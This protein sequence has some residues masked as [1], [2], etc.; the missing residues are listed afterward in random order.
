MFRS[1]LFVSST[2][3]AVVAVAGAVS[4]AGK[5]ASGKYTVFVGTYTSKGSKGIYSFP[6]DVKTAHAG[7]PILAAASEA[8]SFV[9]ASPNHRFL[10]ACNEIDKFQGKSAGSVTGFA[11]EPGGKLKQL[12]VETSGGPGPCWVTVDPTGKNVLVANYGG[13]SIEVIPIGADGK[14]E[15]P[16]TFIQHHGTGPDKARQ[17]GPHAHS[18]YTSPDNRFALA[19]DLGLDKVMVYKFDAKTGKL[20][21]NKPEAGMVPPGS[22]PRHMAFHPD[23]KHVFVINEMKSSLTS[24]NYDAKAGAL[25]PI[26]TLS[27]LPHPVAGNSCAEIAVHPSGKWVYGSNRGHNSIAIFG[28][29]AKT[30]KLKAEG[31]QSTGGKTPRSF[32]ID[33][34]GQVLIA[35]NQDTDNITIFRID[36]A[37]GKLKPTGQSLKVSMPVSLEFVPAG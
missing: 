19:A 25:T 11:I 10:Y 28:F 32:A 18:F 33:P 15:A 37:T 36:Q 7:E 30:G 17:E 35:A 6:F 27:T 21:P 24:F 22:G 34:S 5:S 26:E 23:G 3:V 16:S 8:P 31:H 2:L 4:A 9:A 12:N 29:D 1:L 14:L 13:G 20:T